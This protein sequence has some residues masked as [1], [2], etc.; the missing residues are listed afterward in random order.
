MLD[1]GLPFTLFLVYAVVFIGGFFIW[2]IRS[3]E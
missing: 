3:E 2:A 1:F